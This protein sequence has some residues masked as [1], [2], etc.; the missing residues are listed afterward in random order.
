MAFNLH[1]IPPQTG[2]IAIVTGANIGL[3]YETTLVLAQKGATVIMACRDLQKATKAKEAILQQLPTA[4]LDIMLLDLGDL[5]SVRAFAKAYTDKYDRLDLLIA[6]AGLMIPPFSKTKDGFESQFGVNYLGHFLLTNVL[7][8]LLNKTTGARIVTLSSNAHKRGKIDLENL[9]AEKHYS[10][11]GAY[12]QSKLACLMFAYELQ[13][14][15]E[16]AGSQVIAVSAHPGL[17]N[18]NLWQHV[19]RIMYNILLPVS[20]LFIHSP[21][22]AALPTLMAALDEGVKGGSYFGPTGFKEF[23]GK[24]GLV[25]SI[26]ASYDK[27]IAEKLWAVS[28]QMTGEKFIIGQANNKQ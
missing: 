14:R 23:T 12:S 19:P 17:S 16:A 3:G 4:R 13:R 22:E 1:N 21:K 18:T 24:P 15:L 6:N 2:R 28:E 9:N 10:K 27:A 5:H 25:R 11:W 8:P 7:F 26:P 20:S